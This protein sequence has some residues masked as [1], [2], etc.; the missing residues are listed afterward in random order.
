[1]TVLIGALLFSAGYLL[2]FIT[3]ALCAAAR[4]D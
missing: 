4:G 1:M 3:A 2:G